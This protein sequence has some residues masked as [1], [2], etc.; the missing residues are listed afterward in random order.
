MVDLGALVVVETVCRESAG[1]RSMRL[2]TSRAA[3]TESRGVHCNYSSVSLGHL[4]YL[5][6][7]AAK[8]ASQMGGDG[9]RD[10]LFLTKGDF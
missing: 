4:A 8:P 10:Y 5:Q 2:E 1:L 3:L 9:F 7:V 6:R